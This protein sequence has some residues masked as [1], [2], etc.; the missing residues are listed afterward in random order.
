MTLTPEEKFP[1]VET[2]ASR[3]RRRE[4]EGAEGEEPRLRHLRR[5]R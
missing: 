3:T 2:N 5:H 1:Y 4:P